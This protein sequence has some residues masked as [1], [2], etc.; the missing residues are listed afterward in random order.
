[1]RFETT[2]T[3]SLGR[4]RVFSIYS[5]FGT[6]G[7]IRW[8]VNAI[9]KLAGHRWQ[10][11]SEMW[12]L[13]SLNGC[14]PMKKL[15]ARDGANSDVLIVFIGSLE[16]RKPELIEWLD[17]LAPVAPGRSGLLIGLL[18]DEEN[19]TRELDWTARELIRCAQKANRKFLWNWAGHH[20]NDESEWLT[21]G[22]ALLLNYKR[23]C[24]GLVAGLS[25]AAM[26]H[27][28]ATA[29]PLPVR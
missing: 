1:M 29:K 7:R 23:N 18:G 3:A 8:T 19:R 28:A 9:A 15:V 16:Q 17:A 10:C 27:P 21:E 25:P 24:P 2:T 26:P 4:L 5:D 6:S 11:S 12:R 22:V 14:E 20:D 13:D